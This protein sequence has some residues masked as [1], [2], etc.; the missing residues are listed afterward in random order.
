MKILMVTY[1]YPAHYLGRE[2]AI[3]CAQV[4]GTMKGTGHEVRVLTSTYGV[5]QTSA[6]TICGVMMK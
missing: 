1:L 3:H 2:Y 5:P 6:G 4:A